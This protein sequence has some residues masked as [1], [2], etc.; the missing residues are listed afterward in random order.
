MIIKILVI[1]LSF[2]LVSCKQQRKNTSSIETF[3]VGYDSI[4]KA[5]GLPVISGNLQ[6][7]DSGNSC[8]DPYTDCA[9]FVNQD[10]TTKPR[11]DRKDIYWDSAG[12]SLERNYFIGPHNEVLQIYYGYKKFSDWTRLGF[13]YSFRN[14]DKLKLD[15]PTKSKVDSILLSW[16]IRI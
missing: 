16:K 13:G 15:S 5:I 14:Q 1:I 8:L 7:N 10:T 2:S 6:L 11:F 9:M 4:R 12:I 3:G